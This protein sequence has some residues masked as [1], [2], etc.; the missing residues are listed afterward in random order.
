MVAGI[1][2]NLTIDGSPETIKTTAGGTAH[3]EGHTGSNAQL[4]MLDV[5]GLHAK[6]EPKWTKPRASNLPSG[7]DVRSSIRSPRR[8]HFRVS[9]ASLLRA[10]PT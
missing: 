8:L 6:L 2:V 9:F 1:D 10:E 7:P 4:K 5:S 3:S